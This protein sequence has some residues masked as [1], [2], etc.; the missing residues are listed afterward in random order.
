M[1]G[2][3]GAGWG[4]LTR[5]MPNPRSWFIRWLT[6]H[7]ACVSPKSVP[8]APGAEAACQAGI[9]SPCCLLPSPHVPQSKAATF[10][11]GTPNG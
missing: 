4:L 5:L 1:E 11:Q 9:P 2:V 10:T 8:R 7:P 6:F 3:F